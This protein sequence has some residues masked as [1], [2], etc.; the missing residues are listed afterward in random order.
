MALVTLLVLPLAVA[1]AEELPE[2]SLSQPLHVTWELSV[3]AAEAREALLKVLEDEDFP[4]DPE[5][6]VEGIVTE[7]VPFRAEQFGVANIAEDAPKLSDDYLF[8]QRRRV[9]QGRLRLR[10]RVEATDS[11]SRVHVELDIVVKAIHPL[12]GGMGT[13][14]TRRSNGAIEE[15]LL[16]RLEKVLADAKSTAPPQP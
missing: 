3:D 2:E 11:G 14:T 7:L 1:V 15:Y 13:E 8:M 16:G 10:A 6:E 4:L 12:A 5:A 9:K